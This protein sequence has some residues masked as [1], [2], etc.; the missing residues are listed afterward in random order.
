M[1]H[2]LDGDSAARDL[3]ALTQ[4]RACVHDRDG[5]EGAGEGRTIGMSPTEKVM[6]SASWSDRPPS[7]SE[8][9]CETGAKEG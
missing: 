7:C 5:V 3:T 6:A 2:Q 9:S 4:R 1:R 8:E